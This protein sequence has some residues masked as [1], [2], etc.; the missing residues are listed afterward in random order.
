MLWNVSGNQLKY[1][2]ASEL[3]DFFLKGE[4]NCL[5]LIFASHPPIGEN[6]ILYACIYIYKYPRLCI[7]IIMIFVIRCSQVYKFITITYIKF[8]LQTHIKYFFNICLHTLY[9]QYIHIHV[10]VYLQLWYLSFIVCKFLN[11]LR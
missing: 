5:F 3:S 6:I 1:P 4:E 8:K 9:L 11:L 2:K 7:F 10:Y